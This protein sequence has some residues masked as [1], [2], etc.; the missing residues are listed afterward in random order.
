MTPLRSGA[1]IVPVLVVN[2]APEGYDSHVVTCKSP[3]KTN[4]PTRQFRIMFA[5]HQGK[6][7]ST[8]RYQVV[9][10]DTVFQPRQQTVGA[11]LFDS[12]YDLGTMGSGFGAFVVVFT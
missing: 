8:G 9:G 6:Q 5:A 10:D 11:A 2:A 3:R 7:A 1:R 4:D 12:D